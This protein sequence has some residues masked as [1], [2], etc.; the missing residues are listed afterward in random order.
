MF[1]KPKYNRKIKFFNAEG[2]PVN[3][4]QAAI[5]FVLEEE[6]SNT[7][8]LRLFLPKFLDTELIDVDVQP[9][10]IRYFFDF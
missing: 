8:T 7:T 10:Y 2:A 3:V 9:T 6:D 1:E 4:N 5:D